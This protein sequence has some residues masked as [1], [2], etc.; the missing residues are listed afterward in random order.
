MNSNT[1]N[2]VNIQNIPLG[3]VRIEEIEIAYKIFG[4]G[5]PLLLISGSGNVMD[6]WPSPM[7]QELSSN[8]TVI[9][10]DHRGVGNTTSGSK[11]ITIQQLA[12]DTAGFLESIELQ[13]ADVLGFSMGS[14]VAE[15]LA[16]LHPDK[17]NRLILYGAACGGQEGIPQSPMVAKILSDFVNNRTHDV[18]AFLSVTFPLEW[19]KAHPNYLETIP[20]TTE[21][22][23]SSTLVKQFAVELATIYDIW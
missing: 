15:Q 23:L 9:I 3:K 22:I 21:I 18:D 11:P 10:F 20:R 7:L 8:H 16:L 5:D 17:V 12:N 13:K 1:T 14:F 4:N 19:V 6:V 2:S